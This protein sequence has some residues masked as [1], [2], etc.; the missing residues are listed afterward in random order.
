[1][2]REA[3]DK[4]CM[5]LAVLSLDVWLQTYANDGINSEVSEYVL[6]TFTEEFFKSLLLKANYRILINVEGDFLRGYALINFESNFQSE[7]Y[8]YEIE[9]LYVQGAFQGKSIGRSLLKEL[10]IRYGKKFWLYTWVLNKSLGFYKKY[11]FIDVGQYNFNFGD[12]FIENRVLRYVCNR[13]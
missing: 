10:E 7:D 12:S 6:S 5:K 13:T 8:G 4:D 2:I 1:M 9:K 11:G 3:T